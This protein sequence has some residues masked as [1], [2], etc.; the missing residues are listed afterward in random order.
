M[1]KDSSSKRS[2][3][4]VPKT[5]GKLNPREASPKHK[6][7][8][9][10]KAE[11]KAP[12]KGSTAK[13]QS[14][15]TVN[16][17]TLLQPVNAD[18]DTVAWA[19][20]IASTESFEEVIRLEEARQR[21]VRHPKDLDAPARGASG[22]E[23]QENKPKV[24]A[25]SGEKTRKNS[26]ELPAGSVS[27]SEAQDDKSAVS[28]NRG[29]KK[30]KNSEKSPARSVDKATVSSN[31]DEQK[32]KKDGATP[33]LSVSWSDA[34]KNKPTDTS[35]SCEKTS[36]N[37]E[38]SPAGNVPCSEMQEDKPT[39][40]SNSGEKERNKSVESPAESI[41][42]SEMQEDKLEASNSSEPNVTPKDAV[43][44]PPSSAPS[45]T[46]GNQI[47]LDAPARDGPTSETA[48]DAIIDS[49][50]T[51]PINSC[52][53]AQEKADLMASAGVSEP[54]QT[55]DK[56]ATS[57]VPEQ[58]LDQK[59][60][61]PEHGQ[62]FAALS[63]MENE[64]NSESEQR[65][66]ALRSE[67]L[68]QGLGVIR[69]VL[70]DRRY[71]VP[72]G[73]NARKMLE[74]IA[75]LA[76]R[77]APSQR[78]PAQETALGL[79]TDVFDSIGHH[80]QNKNAWAREKVISMEAEIKRNISGVA[81]LQQEI[82]AKDEEVKQRTAA[83]EEVDR[84][85]EKTLMQLK[86]AEAA[87][88]AA[89]VAHAERAAE[90]ARC[91]EIMDGSYKALR[92][93]LWGW[94]FAIQRQH[95]TTLQHFLKELRTVKVPTS[96][97]FVEGPNMLRLKPDQRPGCSK[98]ILLEIDAIFAKHLAAIDTELESSSTQVTNSVQGIANAQAE[99][100][101]AK[102]KSESQWREKTDAEV[103]S[104]DLRRSCED[105]QKLTLELQTALPQAEEAAKTLMGAEQVELE[106]WFKE[107]H[108][109]F[110]KLRDQ[111][112]DSEL[113]CMPTPAK[114]RRS[115]IV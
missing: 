94:D 64:I 30:R 96:L 23:V 79:L 51:Q 13:A 97:I 49:K 43:Q 99:V 15:K 82:L 6:T 19:E 115:S 4:V 18:Q 27:C 16:P 93:G 70:A 28:S 38:E 53:E 71:E 87:Q 41:S 55:L 111:D 2:Q 34:R 58:T 24:S 106:H 73:D 98:Q 14:S 101:A 113:G 33:F 62:A 103:Q 40:S 29:E 110:V 63:H 48:V 72:G 76:L 7:K 66:S 60:E 92:E 107:A 91:V 84:L 22:S 42:S 1:P 68:R 86:E 59:L 21:G 10:A 108:S 46:L 57:S 61:L 50:V 90:R 80:L 9:N 8:G 95:M 47:I 88:V 3:A 35:N 25:N 52:T 109:A 112:L 20:A 74:G 85:L 81:R 39:V 44:E 78:H 17:D 11:S 37:N 12:K 65:S 31:T 45:P 105:L 75:P 26:E 5:K 32:R 77:S 36:K 67:S 83:A 56:I 114:K 104:R 54:F 100:A 102:A 69:A 89:E